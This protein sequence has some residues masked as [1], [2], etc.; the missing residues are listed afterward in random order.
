MCWSI[1]LMPVNWLKWQKF[2]HKNYAKSPLL[3]RKEMFG[4]SQ[5][6]TEPWSYFQMVSYDWC[7][8]DG[9]R[10]WELGISVCQV[11]ADPV[12]L[13]QQCKHNGVSSF[14]SG[15]LI[16][17]SCLSPWIFF[18]PQNQIG[19]IGVCARVYCICLSTTLLFHCIPLP[20]FLSFFF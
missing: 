20:A 13:S 4:G 5:R 12:C 7:L 2:H 16:T 8:G 17:V 15:W 19:E 9:W 18:F 10:A 1:I 6:G 14:N 11:W 3:L